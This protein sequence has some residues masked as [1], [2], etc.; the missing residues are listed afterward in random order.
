[1]IQSSRRAILKLPLQM[2]FSFWRLS[3]LGSVLL[4][5]ASAHA[6]GEVT[7]TRYA[8][9]AAFR[10]RDGGNEAVIVPALG[11]VMSFGPVGGHNLLWNNV[12]DQNARR[13]PNAWQNWGGDKAWPAPQSQWPISIGHEWPPHPSWD[14]LPHAAAVLSGQRVRLVSGYWPVF[15]CRVVREFGF[16]RRAEGSEFVIRQTFEKRSGA[17]VRLSLWSVTQIVPPQAIFLPLNPESSYRNGFHF[18]TKPQGM[19]DISRVDMTSGS[20]ASSSNSSSMLR[21]R[22]AAS[23]SYKIGIDAA[24]ESRISTV[25]A[26]WNDL[27]LRQSAPRP[28][29]AYPDGADGAGFSL[30]IFDIGGTHAG[31]KA[32]L[33]AGRYLELELLSPLR[34]FRARDRWTHTI[35]WSLH[36]LPT[37]DL[38]SPATLARL[39]SLLFSR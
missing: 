16:Q 39:Q 12:P 10:L 11:R 13:D 31:D 18:L 22:P 17:P 30:E 5:M 23:G 15:E 20:T 19:A 9:H 38:D 29:G 35:R 28:E 8:G 25:L 4:Q 26:V 32:S 36:R 27:A 33:Q 1:M 24:P 37:N 3:L 6:A 7:S 2:R 14:G 34:V 21:V